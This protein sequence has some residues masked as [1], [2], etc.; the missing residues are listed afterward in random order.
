MPRH[1][2]TLSP[3]RGFIIVAIAGLRDDDAARLALDDVLA[4]RGETGVTRL[5]FD[6][7]QTRVA[8]RPALLLARAM[9]AGR[10]VTASRIAI[11]S[12]DDDDAHARIWRKGLEETGHEALVFTDAADAQAWLLTPADAALVYL[13]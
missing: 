4:L 6:T 5:M 1:H 8:L 3:C 13:S 12:D 10:S 11:V 2:V 7:R 9:A